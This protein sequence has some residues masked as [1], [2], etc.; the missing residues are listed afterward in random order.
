MTGAKP[1]NRQTLRPTLKSAPKIQPK[2]SAKT[3]PRSPASGT[4]ATIENDDQ[5]LT[6]NKTG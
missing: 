2:S 4:E 5:P 1:P 6:V 3:P